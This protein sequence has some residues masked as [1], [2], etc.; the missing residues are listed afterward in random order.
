MNGRDVR[1][2]LLERRYDELKT[3]IRKDLQEL[4]IKLFEDKT[5]LG[6]DE[7]SMERPKQIFYD[8]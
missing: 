5:D 7:L 3:I 6:C 1:R 2:L 4:V 8:L